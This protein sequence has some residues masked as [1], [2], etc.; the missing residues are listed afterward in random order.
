MDKE[1]RIEQRAKANNALFDCSWYEASLR[2]ARAEIEREARLVAT[3]RN[4]AASVRSDHFNGICCCKA[5]QA[6]NA[7]RAYEAEFAPQPRTVEQIARDI[8]RERD[9]NH[10]ET[11]S[12]VPAAL[13]DEL[14]AALGKDGK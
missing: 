12:T 10:G 6:H 13:L 3:L 7:V 8:Q 5:C 2:I 4:I 1:Q 14:A 11:Y 9:R